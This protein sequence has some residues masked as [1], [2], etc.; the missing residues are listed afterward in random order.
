MGW[1]WRRN[2]PYYYQ[3]RRVGRRVVSDYI[4]TGEVAV[5]AARIDQLDQERRTQERIDRN[6]FADFDTQYRAV[7][8]LISGAI[9]GVLTAAGYHQHKR[10]WRKRRER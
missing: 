3:S 5:L 6:R 9:A 4:G 10:Q 7:D 8:A 2:R 1:K